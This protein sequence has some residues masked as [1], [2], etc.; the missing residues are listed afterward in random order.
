MR[1]PVSLRTATNAD[2]PAIRAVGI[3][4]WHD[5][6]AGLLPDAYIAWALARWWSP[7]DIQR[8]ILSEQF[9]VLV[10]TVDQQVVGIAHN[11]IRADQTAMLWRLYVSQHCRGSGIGTQLIAASEQRLPANI[12]HFG[13]EYY[14][15]NT[16][17]AVWYARLGFA[18]ER[19]EMVMF[20]QVPI[21]S[22]FVQRPR[23]AHPAS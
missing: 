9:S 8:H 11:Q 4:A 13:V 5:T 19:T 14:Q 18:F 15:V 1:S 2:I 23:I 12:Q 22:V 10:A 16:C 20:Q 6:Y 7:E 21:V 3:A 17:A